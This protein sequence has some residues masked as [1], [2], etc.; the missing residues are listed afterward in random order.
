L[1]ADCFDAFRKELLATFCR[2]HPGSEI[3]SLETQSISLR[4]SDACRPETKQ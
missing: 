1:S 2:S 4:R 3:S